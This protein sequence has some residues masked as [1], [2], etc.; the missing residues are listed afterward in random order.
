MPSISA[1]G[2][3]NGILWTIDPAAQLHA[4]DAADLSHQLNQGSVSSFVKFS[5]PTIANGKVYVGTLNSLDVFG[6]QN[7]AF[8]SVASVVSA[9]GFQPGPVAPGSIVSLFGSNLAP[10]SALASSALWPRVLLGTSVFI[11]GVAAALAYVSPTQINAQIP[12]ATIAGQATVN[13]VAGDHVLPPIQVTVQPIAPSLFVDAQNHVMAQNQDGTANGANHPAAPGTLLTA[14]L[15]GQGVNP[16]APIT[17]MLGEQNVQMV[18]ARTAPGMV[19]VL[20]ITVRVPAFAPGGY[21]LT[22]DIGGVVSNA[23][24]VS[25]GVN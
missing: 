20:E 17:A 2:A 10:G 15:T 5:T 12:D 8:G 9:A 18:S 24:A 23:A 16:E 14:Y 19:G 11:N 1:N 4:Y 6:I 22:V 7:T 21:L 25:V 3:T 13:V